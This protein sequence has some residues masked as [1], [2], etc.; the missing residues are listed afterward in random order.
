M[1]A[2]PGKAFNQAC[3]D[4]VGPATCHDDRNRLGRILGC[5]ALRIPSRYDDDIYL[6]PYQLG[7]KLRSPIELSVGIA[8]LDGNVL[9]F[10]VAEFAQRQP[11]C[12]RT[13][14][15]TSRTAVR[16]V[17]DPGDFLRLLRPC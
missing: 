13:G 2:R 4:G 6:E 17:A 5:P 1:P 14:G 15:L 16:Q 12:L 7:R 8:I 9:P 11:N 10:Y 3:L